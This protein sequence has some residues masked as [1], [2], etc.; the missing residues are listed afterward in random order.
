[1]SNDRCLGEITKGVVCYVKEIGF[2][3]IVVGMSL[4]CQNHPGSSTEKIDGKEE[5]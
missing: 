2:Y 1:M 4:V 5:D 3:L